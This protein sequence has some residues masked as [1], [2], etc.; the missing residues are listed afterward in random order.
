MAQRY[1]YKNK[2]I[3]GPFMPCFKLMVYPNL[4]NKKSKEI[5]LIKSSH[6]RLSFNYFHKYLSSFNLNKEDIY[7]DN[8]SCTLI[9]TTILHKAISSLSDIPRPRIIYNFSTEETIKNYYKSDLNQFYIN[10]YKNL[11]N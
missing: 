4:Y 9:D 3:I 7:N 6:N 1:I 5:S 8:Y 10:T 11:I 2:K